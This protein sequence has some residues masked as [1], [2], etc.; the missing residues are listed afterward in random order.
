MVDAQKEYG[1]INMKNFL[2]TGYLFDMDMVFDRYPKELVPFDFDAYE[3]SPIR[4]V[5]TATNCKTGMRLIL[6]KSMTGS[7]SWTDAGLL[8]VFH[9]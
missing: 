4:C 8:P 6:R 5:M 1:Y 2:K 3:K 7:G 9:L